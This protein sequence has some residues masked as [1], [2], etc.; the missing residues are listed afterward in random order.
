MDIISGCHGENADMQPVSICLLEMGRSS[1][2]AEV[3]PKNSHLYLYS[4][5][6]AAY[7]PRQENSTYLVFKLFKIFWQQLRG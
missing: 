1:A 3:R 4:H 5:L 6:F 7:F 2:D